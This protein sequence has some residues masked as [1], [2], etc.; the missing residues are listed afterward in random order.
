MGIG[1]WETA[2]QLKEMLLIATPHT[3]LV[4]YEWG[5]AFK[6]LQPPVPFNVISNKGLPIDRA[7]CDLVVQAR[8]MGA[9]HIFFLDSDV[10]VPPD[11]LIKLW[12]RRLPIV[13]G[14]YGS[15]HEAPG[16][17]IEQL[18]SGGARYAPVLPSVLEQYPLFSHPDIVLG[19]GCALID[20]QV[21]TRLEEPYFKWTQGLEPNGVSE[22]FY[23]FEKCRKAGIPIHVD[24]TVRCQHGDIAGSIDWTGKRQRVTI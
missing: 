19:L 10:I 22:D 7:R 18:K 4:Q 12:N 1:A 3:G 15:K 16:V 20:M 9:S 6:I 17:W 5:V 8:S 24:S 21:F 14:V 13:C 23:F 11:G 2:A